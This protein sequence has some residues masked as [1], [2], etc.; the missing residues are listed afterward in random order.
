MVKELPKESNFS[1]PGSSVSRFCSTTSHQAFSA[2]RLQPLH[3]WGGKKWLQRRWTVTIPH[4][5][6]SFTARCAAASPHMTTERRHA[7]LLLH[8]AQLVLP[9]LGMCW[10]CLGFPRITAVSSVSTV[11]TL[12]FGFMWEQSLSP[13][14]AWRY[15]LWENKQLA[16]F[17]ATKE[18]KTM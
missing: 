12:R 18:D 1:P 15:P 17:C 10:G 5:G 13:Q 14:Q 6:N 11:K 9:V 8:L 16:R 4:P 2:P 7:T 3:C